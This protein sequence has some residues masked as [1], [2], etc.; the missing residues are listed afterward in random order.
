MR[1]IYLS[2]IAITCAVFLISFILNP[3]AKPK[4]YPDVEKFYASL[5]NKPTSDESQ[6]ALRDLASYI[7]MSATT[8]KKLDLLFTCADNS[9]RSIIA[10]VVL[11]SLLNVNKISKLS[12]Y[13]CGSNPTEINADLLAALT[14]HGFQVKELPAASNGKKAYSISFGENMSPADVYAKGSDESTVPKSGFFQVTMCNDGCPDLSTAK[15]KA[16]LTY[17]NSAGDIE[18]ELTSVA[19][20]IVY[21]FNAAK[22]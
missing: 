5:P 3:Y 7:N 14:K 19:T 21:A 18:K 8:D 15:Y 10:Q 9:T 13:S 1:K 17:S 6:A 22:K 20:D 11:Q 2:G 4:L 12:V 16:H